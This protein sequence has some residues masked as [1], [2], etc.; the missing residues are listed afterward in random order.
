M[1][2]DTPTR[3]AGQTQNRPQWPLERAQEGHQVGSFL[4]RENETKVNLVVAH[5]ALDGR[6]N[7]LVEVR[8]ARS[9]GPDRRRLEATEVTPGPGDVAPAR[10]GQLADHLRVR[11]VAE[12]VERQ[13]RGACLF[14]SGAYVKQQ[15]VEVGAVVCR[16]VAAAATASAGVSAVE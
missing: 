16:V 6:G 15:V 7:P 3:W 8:R 9:E 4:V 13:V 14:L 10:I 1:R 2:Y 5:H 11:S 12:G